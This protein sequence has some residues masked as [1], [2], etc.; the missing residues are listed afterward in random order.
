[1]TTPAHRALQRCEAFFRA[2]CHFPCVV[3]QE[4]TWKAEPARRFYEEIASCLGLPDRVVW[5]LGDWIDVAAERIRVW[6]G[7]I[8]EQGLNPVAA[9]AAAFGGGPGSYGDEMSPREA[10]AVRALGLDLDAYAEYMGRAYDEIEAY[11]HAEKAVL[12][13]ESLS[14]EETLRLLQM[15]NCDFYAYNRVADRVFAQ[16]GIPAEL[17]ER[18]E[19]FWRAYLVLDLIADH[20]ADLREDLEAGAYNLL[21]LWHKT[22]GGSPFRWPEAHQRLRESGTFAA[23]LELA[24]AAADEARAA[25]AGITDPA[26]RRLLSA[27]LEGEAEGMR[28]FAELDYLADLPWTCHEPMTLLLMKPHPW[29]RTGLQAVRSACPDFPPLTLS[30]RPHGAAAARE[31]VVATLASLRES[32]AID[33]RPSEPHTGLLDP[34][35]EYSAAGPC[36]RSIIA[37]PSRGCRF[38][39]DPRTTCTH[40]AAYASRLLAGDLAAEDIIGQCAAQLSSLD[41]K[42]APV[43][44]LYVNGNFLDPAE[45]DDDSRRGILN[46][47]AERPKVR[48]II[49]E[50]RPELVTLDAVR[51]VRGQLPDREIEVGLGYDSATEAVRELCLNKPVPPGCLQ[52]AIETLHRVGMRALVYASVKPPFLTE[53]EAIAD[54]VRTV[55]EA[56]DLAADAVSLE[57]VAVQRGTLVDLLHQRGAY[58]PASLWDLV[59]AIRQT[60]HRG[61]IKVGGE[62]FDPAPVVAPANCGRCDATVHAALRTFS[63]TQDIGCLDGLHCDCYREP[64][65]PQDGDLR[66]GVLA[67]RICE[68]LAPAWAR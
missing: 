33:A 37:I 65:P 61:T 43:V 6:D 19:A 41:G 66:E 4:S 16:Q 59:T 28:A 25:L 7:F 63:G 23:F 51:E 39:A 12:Q 32:T 22:H 31:L 54:A 3:A 40:C 49:V 14:R 9:R 36:R 50:C 60:H 30:A 52:T 64:S 46:L 53:Q 67:E 68:A 57:P 47:V 62:V 45:M 55:N 27:Y 42:L 5:A 24:E 48:K 10:Q 56:F 26:L 18:S 21:L 8:D 29:E 15:G 34:C 58:T 2:H 38:A 13:A 11:F 17:I 20:V 44:C 35:P 1:M